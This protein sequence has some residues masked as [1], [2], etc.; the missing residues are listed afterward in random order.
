L[1][2]TIAEAHNGS[3]TTSY[4]FNAKEQDIKTG[5]YFYGPRFYEPVSSQWLSA[6]DV[7]GDKILAEVLSYRRFTTTTTEP[8]SSGPQY[9]SASGDKVSNGNYGDSGETPSEDDDDDKKKKQQKSNEKPNN[10]AKAKQAKQQ[11]N[12][13]KRMYRQQRNALQHNAMFF[14]HTTPVTKRTERR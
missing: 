12:A 13:V 6:D 10:T 8:L 4:L 1:G 14:N 5:Y 2:E 3:F 11:Q 7:T 9:G